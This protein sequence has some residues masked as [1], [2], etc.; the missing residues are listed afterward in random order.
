[1]ER[2]EE[3][4]DEEGRHFKVK[5]GCVEVCILENDGLYYF[6]A[7]NYGSREERAN[8]IDKADEVYNFEN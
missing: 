2:Y 7:T 3:M 5:V 4:T 6:E 8:A 1:M